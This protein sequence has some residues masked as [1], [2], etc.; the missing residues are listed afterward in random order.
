MPPDI[1]P[2]NTAILGLILTAA[3]ATVAATIVASIIEVAK[4][5]PL[6]GPWLEASTTRKQGAA[7]LLSFLLVIYA[8]VTTT[9]IVDAV[10][11]FAAFL[12]FLGVAGLATKAYD[13]VIKPVVSPGP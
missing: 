5:A 2:G 11:A 9:P 1:D 4:H 12:A 10:N 6:V 3:G 7:L 13:A 8:Y